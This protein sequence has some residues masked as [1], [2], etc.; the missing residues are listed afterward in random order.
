MIISIVALSAAFF[1]G[2][3]WRD[4]KP[5]LTAWVVS[6]YKQIVG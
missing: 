1:S 6:A 4:V 3:Y 2:Y 5:V